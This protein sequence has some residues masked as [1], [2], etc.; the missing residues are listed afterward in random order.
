MH[1][2]TSC[3]R[4]LASHGRRSLRERRGQGVTEP[5]PPELC[6]EPHHVADWDKKIAAADA[7]S[8][9]RIAA[10][11]EQKNQHLPR[12][13]IAERLAESRCFRSAFRMK[14]NS[15]I[16]LDARRMLF[17]TQTRREYRFR[18]LGE[19]QS[20]I[21]HHVGAMSSR[22][23]VRTLDGHV[24]RSTMKACLLE[25]SGTVSGS[26]RERTVAD[27]RNTTSSSFFRDLR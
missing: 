26:R 14:C 4:H 12:G 11:P 27:Q 6:G 5:T 21:S 10:R 9:E 8:F 17:D 19:G 20:K 1:S 16:K 7:C 13:D 2:W 24:S 25:L 22:M 15:M 3:A 18:R 23:Q